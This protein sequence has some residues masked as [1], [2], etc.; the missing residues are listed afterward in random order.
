MAS[1]AKGL[2]RIRNACG[3]SWAGLRAAWRHEEAFRQELVLVALLTPLA[4]WL[5]RTPVELALLLGSGVLVL[6]TELLNTAVEALTD[7]VGFERHELSARAKDLGSAAVMLS[8]GLMAG[9]WVAVAWQRFG[10]A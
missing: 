4:C 6:I 10:A 3:Y 7:R 8:L 1:D 5:G 2:T 9:V